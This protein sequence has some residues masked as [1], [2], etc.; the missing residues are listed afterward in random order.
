MAG[1]VKT[2]STSDGGSTLKQSEQAITIPTGGTANRTAAPV[3]GEFRFN[4][5]LSKMEFY[6]G[7]AF[8]TIPFQGTS[9]ITQ[10]SFTGNGST[11]GFTMSTT[12]TSNQE[13]RVVVA[14]G[15]VFQNPASAYTVS[16]T[17]ITFTSPPGN[18]EPIVVIHGLDSNS[19]TTSVP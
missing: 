7:S 2:K 4:T 3:A 5:D 16:G 8:K 15:N 10:D 6:D 18:S 9:T 17:T 13:Q 1:Y 19:A 14:V 11:T 12:V